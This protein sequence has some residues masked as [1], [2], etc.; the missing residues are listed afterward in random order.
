MTS[1]PAGWR[2]TP[3]V[4][5]SE[6]LNF[7]SAFDTHAKDHE[8]VECEGCKM[9][10]VKGKGLAI[11]QGTCEALKAQREAKAAHQEHLDLLW[12]L[13]GDGCVNIV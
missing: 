13:K 5:L 8:Y 12:A 2:S 1:G 6:V 11:H 10:F 9:R 3:N 4:Y 7:T